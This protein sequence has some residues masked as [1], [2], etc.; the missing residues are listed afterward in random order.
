LIAAICAGEPPCPPRT[1]AIGLP[2]TKYSAPYTTKLA[3]SSV[4][5]SAKTRLATNRSTAYVQA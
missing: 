1:N 2:G 3:S 5:T 4:T